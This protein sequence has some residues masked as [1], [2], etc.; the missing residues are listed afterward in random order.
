MWTDERPK[1][2]QGHACFLGLNGPDDERLGWAWFGPTRTMDNF[3]T[4]QAIRAH[5]GATFVNHLSAGG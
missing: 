2:K 5:G 1:T 4:L 3:E